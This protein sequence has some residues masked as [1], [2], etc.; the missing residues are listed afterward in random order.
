MAERPV[1]NYDGNYITCYPGSNQH[2][3]GK[4]NLEFNMAR[5]VTRVTSKNFCNVKPSFE[6]TLMRSNTGYPQ[7]QVGQGQCSIN[8]RDIIITQEM[9]ID[10]PEKAGTFYLALHLARD[11]HGNVFGDQIYGVTTTFM[12]IYLTYFDEKPDPITDPDILYL[13]KVEFDGENITSLEEDE[14]KYG[15][16]WAEDILAKMKD[17]KHPEITRMILQDLIYKFPDWYVS[18]E[19][20]VIYGPLE[21]LAGRN[22]EIP[23]T[24][25]NHEDIG[26]GKY[27]IRAEAIL[28]EDGTRSAN[29]SI[30]G[31]D[32]DTT[33][34]NK[35]INILVNNNG[36]EAKMGQSILV[37]N[38]TN[39]FALDLSTP[40]NIN[41]N[42]QGNVSIIGQNGISIGTGA[43]GQQPKL[44][45][46]DNKATISHSEH[47]DLVD[48]VSFVENGLQHIIGK[49]IFQHSGNDLTLL[50]NNTNYF[51]V[52]PNTDFKSNIRVKNNIYLGNSNTYGSEP[53][54][55][56]PTELKLV[57]GN[58]STDI[59]TGSATLINPTNNAGYVTVK[60]DNTAY[61][62]L[63]N[64]GKLELYNTDT[65]N[66]PKILLKNGSSGYDISIE[67]TVGQNASGSTVGIM[68]LNAS[69]VKTS[70][71]ITATGDIRARRVYNAV[72]NDLVEFMRKTDRTEVIEPG[73][74][75]YFDD[76]GN[77]TKTVNMYRIA[78]IVSSE[79]TYGLV[80][81]GEG[82]EDDEKVPVALAGRVY[83][84]IGD[85]D[86]QI[87]DIL[88]VDNVG[89]IRILSDWNRFAIG[90]A[91]TPNIDGK[92]YTLVR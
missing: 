4:L 56:T 90:K 12:G 37:S 52:T 32:V 17:W 49:S 23:G 76:E 5:L 20:D 80:L 54:F 2:D 72:Y 82:L 86:V 29:I 27:G 67:Q 83:L 36:I 44:L 74:I 35:V 43:N 31:P 6:L 63:Y 89:N 70:G 57:S 3:D 42:S 26:T 15:R 69:L 58:N 34:P 62:T 11:P 18:K 22:P 24:Y 19:G 92:V 38:T 14:D 8:G 66:T 47:T 53:S 59:L 87:G 78:G 46:Q 73:D 61:G 68:N 16:I 41:I 60:K 28:N 9:I 88:G 30:K 64:T 55:I 48:E 40:N 13:G 84:N 33:D 50:G 1:K 51:N 21:F 81:G 91:T 65:G 75:V 77:V 85:L 71:D 79:D 25:D 45:L 7:I 10:A 39:S